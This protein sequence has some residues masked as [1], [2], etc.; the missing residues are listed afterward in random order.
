MP[1]AR[2][3]ET[4]TADR[5]TVSGL[6]TSSPRRALTAKRAPRGRCRPRRA[7]GRDGLSPFRRLSSGFTGSHQTVLVQLLDERRSRD[8]EAAGG[9]ALVLL[10]GGEALGDD[11]AL[12]GLDPRAQR[13][14]RPRIAA[15]RYLDLVGTRLA[16]RAPQR[17]RQALVRRQRQQ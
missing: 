14:I 1:S 8:A 2:T 10:R 11:R 5:T 4:E 13:V 17:E 6:F 12:E 15:V 3:D 7:A 16:Q 9:L